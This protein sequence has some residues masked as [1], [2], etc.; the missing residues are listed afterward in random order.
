MPLK[1]G[2]NTNGFAHH[3]LDDAIEIIAEIG[4]QS[5]AITLDVDQLNPFG[6][7]I[8]E[9]T[10]HVRRRLEKWGLSCVVVG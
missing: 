10:R 4:Y 8:Q 7:D 5:V 1:L 6:E 2:Y 3:A 9:E